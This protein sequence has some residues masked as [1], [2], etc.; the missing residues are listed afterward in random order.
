MSRGPS[1]S[2]DDDLRGA[3]AGDE[4]AFAAIWRR[5][6]PAL[7]RFLQALASRDDADELASAT[8]LD[9][10]RGLPAFTGDEAGF[11]AWLFTIARSRTADLRRQASRRP[12]TV[13]DDH[14]LDL[15]ES[16]EADPADT[17]VVHD[18]TDAA[19]ALI[20]TLPP[21]QA[22]VL[23]LR[24]VADLD[25]AAVAKIIGKRPGTVRVL[26]HRGLREL[27]RLVGEHPDDHL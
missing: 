18:A 11:R 6:N 9:V 24:I 20:G 19:V 14:G 13:H 4:R 10:T 16:V 8:W 25:V 12:A 23:L 15:R 5:F 26:A 17:V 3:Q 27:A 2:F 21:G 1:P 7:L 22:E